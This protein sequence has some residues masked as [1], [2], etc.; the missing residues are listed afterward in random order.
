MPPRALR[1]SAKELGAPGALI[2][3]MP[4]LTGFP[5]PARYPGLPPSSILSGLSGCI[6]FTDRR[7]LK[8]AVDAWPGVQG[9]QR[10]RYADARQAALASANQ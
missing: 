5:W 7:G 10:L 4:S 2:C 1:V 3:F 8:V 6:A 9:G